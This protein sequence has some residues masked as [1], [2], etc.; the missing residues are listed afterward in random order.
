MIDINRRYQF[1]LILVQ[2]DLREDW[3]KLSL[4]FLKTVTYLEIIKYRG[5]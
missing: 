1:F 3:L 4:A 2:N 5:I